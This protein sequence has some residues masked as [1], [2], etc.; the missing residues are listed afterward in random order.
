M[1][2]HQARLSEVLK[3]PTPKSALLV[4]A[5]GLVGGHC[6]DF[7]L[8]DPAY[9][10]VLVF[11]RKPLSRR[12][13]K[14]MQH[15]IDFEQLQQHMNLMRVNEVF[16]CLGTTIKKAGSQPAF[17]RVDFEYPFEIAKLAAQNGVE[18]FLLVTSIGANSRSAIFYSRVKGEVEAAIR[19]LPFRAIHI[20][21]PSILLGSRAEIR[22]GEKI[23]QMVMSVLAFLFIG[24]LRK[25]R[26][27]AASAV[28]A[29]MLKVAKMNQPGIHVHES[30]RIQA[31]ANN[32]HP[33]RS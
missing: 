31:L 22:L 1:L 12:H 32:L 6:L 5:S 21:R 14:L 28:A 15:V 11:V 9:D 2:Q 13:A 29:A 8:A 24:A 16:C 20:F 3:Q 23:G 4:G 25:Y 26:P 7:L 30:D 33:Q 10:Q 17:R 27:I 19:S 18:Q